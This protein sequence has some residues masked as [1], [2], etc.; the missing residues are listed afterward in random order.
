M[1]S[2][3]S[4]AYFC[5]VLGLLIA[6]WAFCKSPSDSFIH[7]R[8]VKLVSERGACSGEQIEAPS[9]TSY[10]LTAA[11][12]RILADSAGSIRVILEDGTKI[13]RRVIAE[14]PNSDL[15]LLEGVPGLS[16][17]KIA[18]NSFQDEHVR[19]FTHG[20][21]R[22]TYQTEGRLI[23][24][25][26]V[27]VILEI[28]SSDEALSRCK[29]APKYEVVEAESFSGPVSVCLLSVRET[30]TTAFI[31]PG[32]SG[33]AVLDDSGRLLGV[34]SAGDDKFGFLVRRDDIERFLAGY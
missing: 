29:S 19:T 31:V 10:V 2:K 16:G 24:N 11:H 9:G 25:E 33:G 4:F 7:N 28:I 8:V 18:S 20:K 26:V 15:L 6:V 30:V 27:Q 32:S 23:Q 12:C 14:D 34:V 3:A 1:K 21:A 13:S 5:S 17:L 22:N